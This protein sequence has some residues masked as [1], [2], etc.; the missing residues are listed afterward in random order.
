MESQNM[1]RRLW[2]RVAAALTPA[3]V[4]DCSRLHATQVPGSE[5]SRNTAWLANNTGQKVVFDIVDKAPAAALGS[6]RNYCDAHTA[7]GTS[8]PAALALC[9][10][11]NAI[12]TVCG[13]PMWKKY[14]FGELFGISDY[15]LGKP[16]PA[17][18]NELYGDAELRPAS[19]SL[20][21][22]RQFKPTLLVCRHS[23]DALTAMIAEV[24]K[25]DRS[26]VSAD[27]VASFPAGTVE[28]PAG[29]LALVTAQEHGYRY[30]FGA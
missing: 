5:Q 9:F 21:G 19:Y 11:Q 14:G 29:V 13:S 25:V 4:A 8:A 26:V 16:R 10:R 27:L 18:A 20:V 17:T 7:T 15:S 3:L 30:I 23:L 28:V 24:R 2:L 22:L 12:A 6:A 1:T